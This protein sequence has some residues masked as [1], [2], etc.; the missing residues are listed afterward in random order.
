MR[1]GHRKR[2]TLGWERWRSTETLFA[3]QELELG[4]TKLIA[5]DGESKVDAVEDKGWKDEQDEESARQEVPVRLQISLERSVEA[6]RHQ[7][8]LEVDD[9]E[10]WARQGGW[11]PGAPRSAPSLSVLMH[12]AAKNTFRIGAHRQP[13]VCSWTEDRFWDAIAAENNLG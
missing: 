10:A 3:F 8:R 6:D 7:L 12:P 9:P 13:L 4:I 1:I 2:I 11:L 5:S